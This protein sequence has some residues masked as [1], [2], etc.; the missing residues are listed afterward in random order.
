MHLQVASQ[1]VSIRTW[2]DMVPR[3]QIIFVGNKK[4][5]CLEKIIQEFGVDYV[6]LGAIDPG[7]P[8]IP[9]IIEAGER[10]ARN[11]LIMYINTDILLPSNFQTLAGEAMKKSHKMHKV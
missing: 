8:R 3:P 10:V 7:I 1:Y 9:T 11:E 6:D 5:K 4:T 2:L